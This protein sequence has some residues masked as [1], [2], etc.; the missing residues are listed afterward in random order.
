VA[1]IKK[2]NFAGGITI[3]NGPVVFNQWNYEN[4]ISGFSGSI[5]TFGFTAATGKMDVADEGYR[6]N[7]PP[8]PLNYDFLQ[9]V[10]ITDKGFALEGLPLMD[11]EVPPPTPTSGARVPTAADTLSLSS[12]LE[13]IDT[14][15]S[16]TLDAIL[17]VAG[18]VVDSLR[19]R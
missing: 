8:A 11:L 18:A 12:D 15:D 7:I 6:V 9:L 13:L 10:S 14:A 19:F 2:T 16:A 5:G 1:A 4:S 3:S 17:P